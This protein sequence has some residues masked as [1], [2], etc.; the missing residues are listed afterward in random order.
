MGTTRSQFHVQLSAFYDINPAANARYAFEYAP[1]VVATASTEQLATSVGYI[2]FVLACLG[3]MDVDNENNGLTKNGADNDQTT[4]MLLNL[5]TD[6]TDRDL[7][8][9]MDESAFELLEKLIAP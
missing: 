7:G 4:N 6:Q 1:D 3:I 8:D 5:T 2:V 9:I